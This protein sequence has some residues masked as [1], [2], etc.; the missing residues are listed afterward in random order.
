AV[1]ELA[2]LEGSPRTVAEPL[3]LGHVRVVEL[4]LQPA[5]GGGG[6]PACRADP[7][8]RRAAGSGFTAPAH[9]AD[10]PPQTT[11]PSAAMRVNRIPSRTPRSATR[12]EPTGHIA[13]IAAR[14]AQP[15]TTRSARSR[16]TH[17]WAARAR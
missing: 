15:A 10:L 6:S 8:R 7:Y 1:V 13:Q 2:Q 16:P 9:S 3:R 14:M 12:R 11:R 4:A 5:G 17:G